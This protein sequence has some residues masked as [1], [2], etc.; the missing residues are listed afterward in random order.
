MP[1]L[2]NINELSYPMNCLWSTQLVIMFVFTVDASLFHVFLI[3][4]PSIFL[5]SAGLIFKL[6]IETRG[7]NWRDSTDSLMS[8]ESDEK[9]YVN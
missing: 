6:G 2:L 1:E 4:L 8:D 3:I 7:G 9:V 5:V